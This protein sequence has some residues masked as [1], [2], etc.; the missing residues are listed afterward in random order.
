MTPIPLSRN[1]R[2]SAPKPH[3]QTIGLVRGA[4]TEIDERIVDSFTARDWFQEPIL[5]QGGRRRGGVDII[6]ISLDERNTLISY[7]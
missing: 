1:Y 5:P 3:Q 6:I 7:E 2:W 4:E